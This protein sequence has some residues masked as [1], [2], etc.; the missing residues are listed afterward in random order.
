MPKYDNRE[1]KEIEDK[2]R[3]EQKIN[4]QRDQEIKSLE[5]KLKQV[6]NQLYDKETNRA[7]TES[8]ADKRQIKED[9]QRNIRDLEEKYQIKMEQMKKDFELKQ[10]RLELEFE[11]KMQKDERS[12][13]PK[14]RV[15][16]SRGPSLSQLPYASNY[17]SDPNYH[18]PSFYPP[19]D[20][21]RLIGQSRVIAE[22]LKILPPPPQIPLELPKT[23]ELS[24]DDEIAFVKLGI[25][26]EIL[27]SYSYEEP[28]LEIEKKNPLQASDFTLRFVAF[29][30]PISM[31]FGQ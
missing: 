31:P 10:E 21:S 3:L 15:D 6:T 17:L 14:Y 20:K 13:S 2:Y 25:K 28:E 22:D 5:D 30:P 26:E 27:K 11:K 19:S 18:H 12:V 29:K 7:R 16:H 24:R 4:K 9:Q 1:L 23:F 8:N